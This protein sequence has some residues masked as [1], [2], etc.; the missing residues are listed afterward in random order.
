MS[1]GGQCHADWTPTAQLFV[2]I[3]ND[4]SPLD[5]LSLWLDFCDHICDDL[6][7][8]LHHGHIR[9]NPTQDDVYDYGLFLIDH[10]LS[11][12]ARSLQTHW[13]MLPSPQQDWQL[14]VGN[15]LIAEQL[16]YDR[17]QQ[18]QIANQ[19]ILTFSPDQLA[20]FDDIVNAVNSKS[21]QSFFLHG[22]GGTGK[23]YVYNALCALLRG[24]GKIIICV[25]ASGVAALLLNGGCTSHSFF[26]IHFAIH[27]SSTCSYVALPHP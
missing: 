3:L 26:K 25:A 10:I 27:E 20:A 14:H 7:H 4:C 9:L 12:S 18:T 6:H 24:Q 8:A 17:E 23:T 22:A 21:G 16:E 11:A 2:T 15:R 13:P 5:P 1:T 19:C